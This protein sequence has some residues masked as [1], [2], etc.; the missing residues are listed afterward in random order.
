MENFA[1]NPSSVVVKFFK[2]R[3]GHFLDILYLYFR[4]VS[5]TQ[6]LKGHC[7]NFSACALRKAS[8]YAVTSGSESASKATANK[9]V[10]AASDISWSLTL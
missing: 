2:F 6:L 1:Q 7:L 10:L 3:K 8:S 4:K 9:P 5:S